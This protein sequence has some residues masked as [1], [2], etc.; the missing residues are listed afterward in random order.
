MQQQKKHNGSA[1]RDGQEMDGFSQMLCARI[2]WKQKKDKMAANVLIV[3]IW[4]RVINNET[5]VI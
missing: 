4:Q 3:L 1:W 5:E 2:T